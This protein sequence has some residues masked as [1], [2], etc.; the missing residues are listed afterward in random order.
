MLV[1][2]GLASLQ[3][4]KFAKKVLNKNIYNK[5]KLINFLGF[6]TYLFFA[7]F[8]SL[9]LWSALKIKNSFLNK[10]LNKT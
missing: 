2:E 1:E 10:Q 3:G 9:V 7:S 5:V 4:Q 8:S 6:L